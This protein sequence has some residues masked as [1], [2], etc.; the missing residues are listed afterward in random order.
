MVRSA[1]E[2][3]NQQLNPDLKADGF[4]GVKINLN[5]DIFGKLASCVIQ[6]V[7]IKFSQKLLM[8]LH[9]LPFKKLFNWRDIICLTHS[10]LTA[11]LIFFKVEHFR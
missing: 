7:W 10:I 2:T 8:I 3:E 1:E 6:D 9:G 5:G 4:Y 11:E